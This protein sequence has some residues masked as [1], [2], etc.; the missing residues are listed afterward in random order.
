MGEDGTKGRWSEIE[1][2][3]R[4]RWDRLTDDDW[5]IVAGDIEKLSERI[6]ERY[7][8]ARAVVAQRLNKLI[9]VVRE[10]VHSPHQESEAAAPADSSEST[11]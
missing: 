9:A 3:A 7:G 11:K 6:Q 8:E 1:S 2:E 5:K 10:N 4:R